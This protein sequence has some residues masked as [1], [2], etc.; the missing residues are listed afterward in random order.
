MLEAIW[1]VVRHANSYVDAQA[2]W[3]LKKTDTVR[4]ETVLG[5]L[6]EVVRRLATL[7]QPVMPDSAN[8][9]LDQLAV[10]QNERDFASITAEIGLKQGTGIEQPEGVFPRHVEEKAA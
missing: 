3:G 1:V 7:I 8:K 6:C 2:P 9:M 10:P 5:V 4:M